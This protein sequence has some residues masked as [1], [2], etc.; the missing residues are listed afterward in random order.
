MEIKVQ[1]LSAQE[2]EKRRVKSW[3]IWEKEVSQFDWFYD[4][5]EECQFLEGKVTVTPKEG[6]PVSF[7]AGDFVTF[8]KGMACVWQVHEPV[9]KHYRFFD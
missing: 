6:K 1:K 8:P 3:P 9:R 7:G 4:Q 5:H 2:L